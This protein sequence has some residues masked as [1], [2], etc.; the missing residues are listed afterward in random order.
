MV[1]IFISPDCNYRGDA[2][3]ITNKLNQIKNAIYG[4]DV[5]GAIHDAIK[6]VYDDASVNHDNANMEVKMARGTHN[7]LNDRL[8]NV[9]EIQAQTNA[10]L[11]D[12]EKRWNVNLLEFENHVVDNDWTIALNKAIEY[13]AIN[14]KC[15]F[16]PNGLYLISGE[17]FFTKDINSEES[18]LPITI[19]GESA[20]GV[21][22][23]GKNNY[24]GI[25]FNLKSSRNL[26]LENLSSTLYF[27]INQYGSD[28]NL[29][30]SKRQVYIKN[31]FNTNP[32]GEQIN[33]SNYICCPAPTSYDDNGDGVKARYPLEIMNFSGYNAVMIVNKSVDEN[34]NIINGSVDNSAIGITDK[35][36]GVASPS[37]LIDGGLRSFVQFKNP[38]AATKS[39]E[40]LD[41]VYEID[42]SG[43]VAIGCSTQASDSV[44]PGSAV[45]KLRE[46][47][48]S[49]IMYDK[50]R[51]NRQFKLE[52]NEDYT[53][54]YN[55][56]ESGNI[57][58]SMTMNYKSKVTVFKGSVQLGDLMTWEGTSAARNLTGI[59]T[60]Y[61]P[62]SIT[63]RFEYVEGG[64]EGQNINIVS[65]G[66]LTI[67]HNKD[68]WGNIRTCN[69]SNIVLEKGVLYT[70]TRVNGLWYF[71]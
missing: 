51:N 67:E 23:N 33:W 3:S 16:I 5:R 50:N 13:C 39:S 48:P 18:Y 31:V 26:V 21:H 4:K 53:R 43:H 17:V 42:Q 34:G 12:V 6:Q 40:R 8:D 29:I 32:I 49:V 64:C 41:V 57:S 28:E 1:L 47:Y 37:L 66:A 45:L 44:A 11:S 22:I 9:D 71:K 60:I 46:S 54:F 20:N 24:S 55:Y 68:G 35:V 52:M 70:L 56:D 14:N 36:K 61:V 58:N 15:L 38:N 59:T 65:D 30:Q 2:M 62:S 63:S 7:T 27:S 69:K 10:Q 25:G 19:I